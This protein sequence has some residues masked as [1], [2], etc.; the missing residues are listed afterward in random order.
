MTVSLIIINYN[1]FQLTCNCISSVIEHT[2]DVN[3]EIVLVD[4]NSTECDADNFLEKFPGI[5]LVKSK[6]NGGFAKG[7]NLGIQH[8]GGDIILLLNSDTYLTED[9]V[10]KAAAKLVED[11]L[12]GVLGVKMLYP[13][14][15]VQY[16]A[17]RF[18]STVWELLDLFRFI[19]MLMPYKKRAILMLGKYFK[20]D[21]DTTC[22]WL[23]GAFFMFPK[24]I[25]KNLPGEKLDERF[26][27][28]GEDQL[29]CH[30]VKEAGYNCY[31]YSETSIVHINQGST[32]QQKQLRLK[33]IMINSELEIMRV[34][35]KNNVQYWVLRTIYLAKDYSR[36][37]IKLVAFKL[38]GK[39]IK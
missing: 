18:R 8:A 35:K 38:F 25:L 6:E 2:K 31:F 3:Y 28:Y 37:V 14:G 34:R 24:V 10:S 1:T 7:N 5:V 15:G 17:R 29:W 23:N 12:T 19:P 20:G 33:K 32:S 21:F 16:T 9:A 27:M 22:D 36:Y 11:P 4:N 39:L 26:F 13:D 30:Q